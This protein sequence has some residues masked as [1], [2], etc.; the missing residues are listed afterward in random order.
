MK[1]PTPKGNIFTIRGDQEP[2]EMKGKLGERR[3]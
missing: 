2:V 3:I 1:K